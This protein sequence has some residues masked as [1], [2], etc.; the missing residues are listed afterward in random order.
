MALYLESNS[1]FTSVGDDFNRFLLRDHNLRPRLLSLSD[2]AF[3]VGVHWTF[4]D[5]R[6]LEG[7]MPPPRVIEGGRMWDVREIDHATEGLPRLHPPVYGTDDEL[8]AE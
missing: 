4:F 2:A 8:D 7:L 6:V 3:Y 5:R 1:Y